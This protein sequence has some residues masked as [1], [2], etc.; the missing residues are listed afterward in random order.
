MT[1]SLHQNLPFP[2][3][4]VTFEESVVANIATSATPLDASLPGCRKR[5][6]L[7]DTSKQNGRATSKRGCNMGNRCPRF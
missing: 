2:N 3:H 5:S 4:P 1:A 6:S 7:D